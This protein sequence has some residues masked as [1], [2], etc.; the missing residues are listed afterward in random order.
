[1]GAT[2]TIPREKSAETNGA[3]PTW[4]P[5]L[6]DVPLDAIDVG[7]NVRT[8][9]AGLDELAESIRSVGILQPIRVEESGAGR[10]ALVYGQR[11]LAAAREAGLQTIPALVDG[12]NRTGTVLVTT[13]LVENLQ[14][15][16][17]NP[18]EEAAGLRLLLDTEPK[19][20]QAALAKRIGR[21]APYVSN[22]LRLLKV[23]ESIKE[24]LRDGR[25]SGTHARAIASLPPDEATELGRRAQQEKLS[26]HA[27]EAE[28]SRAQQR[29]MDEDRRRDTAANRDKELVAG[30][31]AQL[32]KK[33]ADPTTT[34]LVGWAGTPSDGLEALA[35]LGW[36]KTK[37]ASRGRDTTWT[38][39]AA[40]I[41]DCNAYELS[42][43]LT[44]M[45]GHETYKPNLKPAC[46]SKKHQEAARKVEREAVEK[47]QR[48]AREARDAAFAER[49]A[50]IGPL[51]AA[52]TPALPPEKAKLVLYTL[53]AGDRY[54]NGFH[55]ARSW[56]E[57][58]TGVG[59]GYGNWRDAAWKLIDNLEHGSALV[60]IGEI[61]ASRIVER[62][63][64]GDGGLA[65]AAI[66][67]LAAAAQPT[68]DPQADG[69]LE[70]AKRPAAKKAATS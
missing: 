38:D 41:C 17:L 68:A 40:G 45:S 66:D 19:L 31:L 25:L 22:S 9:V 27:L 36:K 56:A 18:L 8:D 13:Q 69:S 61:I 5:E 60:K 46:I 2:A 7:S 58:Q 24:A 14:R 70:P 1:M 47:Q 10:Y 65:R 30:W 51:A 26:T 29:A 64:A 43:S 53:L 20:N 15:H 62:A 44:Y 67:A 57:D 23:P 6:H 59:L 35:K 55:E 33:K 50:I 34:T 3:A 39:R 49:Q 42:Y 16:D 12:K 32:L 52:M 48:E 28:V 63:D 4:K 21:S 11:R 54:G 37:S